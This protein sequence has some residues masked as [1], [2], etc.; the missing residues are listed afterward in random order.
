[1][2]IAGILVMARPERVQAVQVGLTAVPGV[3]VHAGD[4][5]GQLVVTIEAS[6]E[7]MMSVM[8]KIHDVP[9]VLAANLVYQHTNIEDEER[10]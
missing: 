1:M 9:G 8:T 3:E 10:A 2:D 4:G 5:K 6:S 7:D